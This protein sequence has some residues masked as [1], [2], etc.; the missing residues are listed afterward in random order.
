MSGPPPANSRCPLLGTP[1]QVVD[2]IAQLADAGL[3]GMAISSPDYEEG[4]GAYATQVRPLLV[5]QRPARGLRNPTLVIN[6]AHD[7]RHGRT[8]APRL[9]LGSVVLAAFALNN[10]PS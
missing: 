2:G 9:T 1:E 8:P 3:D 7:G 5:E 6:V 10:T 4:I